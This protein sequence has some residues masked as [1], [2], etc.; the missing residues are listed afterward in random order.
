VNIALTR[1]LLAVSMIA[2]IA[3]S[4]A[5]YLDMM[6][7]QQ[8]T[9][10]TDLSDV[11]SRSMDKAFLTGSSKTVNLKL[12][13]V[14]ISS[15]TLKSKLK[16]YFRDLDIDNDE[17][18]NFLYSNNFLTVYQAD[19][20]VQGVKIHASSPPPYIKPSNQLLLVGSKP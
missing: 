5:V 20:M 18:K 19:V 7:K 14:E 6:N 11:L 15:F 2:I 4:A 16:I 8:K 3:F 13:N 9:S 1:T 17:I 12:N 10:Y